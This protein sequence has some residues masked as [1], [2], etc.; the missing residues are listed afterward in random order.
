[1]E[2]YLSAFGVF[3]IKIHS[4]EGLLREYGLQPVDGKAVPQAIDLIQTELN[5]V[6][7]M[8]SPEGAYYFSTDS[9][10]VYFPDILSRM[11]PYI[12]GVGELTY[13]SVPSYEPDSTSMRVYIYKG[14]VYEDHPE[15]IW[16]PPVVMD[17]SDFGNMDE[18]DD[19]IDI[20]L[21]ELCNKYKDGICDVLQITKGADGIEERKGVTLPLKKGIALAEKKENASPEH[22]V[23]I[24]TENGTEYTRQDL[25]KNLDSVKKKHSTIHLCNITRKKYKEMKRKNQGGQSR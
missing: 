20:R 8:E 23:I 14:S 24:K 1:M 18:I 21:E 6:Y 5:V 4:P 22:P 10:F 9:D 2:R 19:P 7:E 17:L 15:V 25:I 3:S 11:S 13:P 16:H 12:E